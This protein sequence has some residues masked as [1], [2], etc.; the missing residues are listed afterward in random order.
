MPSQNLYDNVTFFEN[1][2]MLPRSVQDLEGA[3]GWP[4]L[5]AFQS[6]LTGARVPDLD[7]GCG[8][9]C[10]RAADHGATTIC[11]SRRGP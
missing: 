9:F 3:P 2:S 6:D 10:R 1:Y 7:G 8:W 5:Q 4:R 11:S